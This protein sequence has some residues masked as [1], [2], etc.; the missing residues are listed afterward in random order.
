MEVIFQFDNDGKAVIIEE[1]DEKGPVY[2]GK[3]CKKEII[4]LRDKK[5][6]FEG[7][8]RIISRILGS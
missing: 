6:V 5:T 2:T 1:I 4:K 8:L 3:I 7:M